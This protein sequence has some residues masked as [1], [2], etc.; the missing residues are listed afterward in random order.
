MTK[1]VEVT[2]IV[3][4]ELSLIKQD[5]NSITHCLHTM[6]KHHAKRDNDTFTFHIYAGNNGF[7][8]LISVNKKHVSCVRIEHRKSS[9]LIFFSGDEPLEIQWR[10]KKEP[11]Y[12]S[13]NG[14]EYFG[15]PF[16]N[17]FDENW[18]DCNVED[19]ELAE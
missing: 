10:S 2:P 14:W 11:N 12:I 17:W 4:H 3:E 13:K 5:I 18:F 8:S 16:M 7:Q 1:N 19:W 9:I 15:E 6:L